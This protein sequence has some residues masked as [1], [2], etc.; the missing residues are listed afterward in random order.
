VF[1]EHTLV[2][3]AKKLIDAYQDYPHATV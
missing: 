2:T 3:D 1:Y